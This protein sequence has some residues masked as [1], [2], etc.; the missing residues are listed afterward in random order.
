MRAIDGN[1]DGAFGKKSVSH[2]NNETK[3]WLEIDLGAEKEIDRIKIYNRRDRLEESNI[4]TGPIV[5]RQK[6]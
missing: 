4:L 1:T 5:R 2:T 3:P 6:V